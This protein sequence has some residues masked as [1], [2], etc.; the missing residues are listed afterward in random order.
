ME[1]RRLCVA[2]GYPTLIHQCRHVK[3]RTQL[4]GAVVMGRIYDG[5]VEINPV[6]AQGISI[7]LGSGIFVDI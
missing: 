7:E 2:I 4:G 1:A 6:D 5:R 3:V